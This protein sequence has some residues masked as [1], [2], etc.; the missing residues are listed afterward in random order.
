M[1]DDD[2]AGE[3]FDDPYAAR[4]MAFLSLCTALETTK[5]KDARALIAEGARALLGRIRVKGDGK[6][7]PLPEKK[8]PDP[9]PL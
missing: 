6:V 2:D 4:A 7:T 1:T 9:K 8:K 5:N 3:S